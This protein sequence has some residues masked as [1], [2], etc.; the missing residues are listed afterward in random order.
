VAL[1]PEPLSLANQPYR[2]ELPFKK[3]VE[4]VS[5]GIGLT[6]A[7]IAVAGPVLLEMREGPMGSST[8]APVAVSIDGTAYFMTA[9]GPEAKGRREA[10]HECGPVLSIHGLG[11]V[12][13]T[14]VMV[15]CFR[16][17]GEGSAEVRQGRLDYLL[18]RREP[19]PI[20]LSGVRVLKGIPY[21]AYVRG[22]S[23]VDSLPFPPGRPVHVY[24]EALPPFSTYGHPA[25][26]E[27][28][29]WHFIMGQAGALLKSDHAPIERLRCYDRV[30]AWAREDI[31]RGDSGEGYLFLYGDRLVFVGSGKG[32]TRRFPKESTEIGFGRTLPWLVNMRRM[33]LADSNGHVFALDVNRKAVERIVTFLEPRGWGVG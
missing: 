23:W 3:T 32:Q 31:G 33:R 19:E 13:D 10:G 26:L 9:A 2:W 1:R 14:P 21:R 4:A 28:V 24:G 15:A 8:A 16:Y 18:P 22:A 6:G 29:G 11:Q 25:L 20:G 30:Y 12:E 7:E 5:Q 27:A 17:P